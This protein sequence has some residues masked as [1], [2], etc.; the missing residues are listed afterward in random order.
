MSKE[1][2]QKQATRILN[3]IERNRVQG[4]SIDNLER[5]LES[6]KEEAKKQNQRLKLY[7]CK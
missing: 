6:I 3:K 5:A 7:A 1:T 2:L 4:Y